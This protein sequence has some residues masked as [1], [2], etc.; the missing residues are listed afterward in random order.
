[1]KT[2]FLKQIV[3]QVNNQS[4]SRG[5]VLALLAAVCLLA[6]PQ[7]VWAGATWIEASSKDIQMG[8]VYA[9]TSNSSPAVSSYTSPSTSG[10]QS[11]LL[12]NADKTFYIWAK[13]ARGYQFSAWT[14]RGG[15]AKAPQT[16]TGNGDVII[17]TTPRAQSVAGTIKATFTPLDAY[18][19]TYLQSDGGSYSAKYGYFLVNAST[20][21]FET[22]SETLTLTPTSGDLKPEGNKT[23]ST[24]DITLSTSSE[25]FVAW[26]KDGAEMSTANPYTGYRADADANISALFKYAQLGTPTGDFSIVVGA[27]S[28]TNYAVTVPVTGRGPWAAGDFTISFAEQTSPAR[29]DIAKGSATYVTV[30]GNTLASTGT[31]SIPFTYS[32]T[33]WGNTEVLV[34]VTPKTGGVYGSSITF[35]IRASAVEPAQYEAEVWENGV[36]TNHG[37][38][39]AMVSYANGLTNNPTVKL[40][41]NKTIAAP[42]SLVQSMTFDLNDMVLTGAAAKAFSIDAADIDVQIVDGGFAGY[43]KISV[44]SEQSGNV[45]VVTFTAKAKLT[46][47][48][49]TL[50]ATNTGTGGAYGLDVRQGSVFYMTGGNL[51][52]TAA[53]DA[54]GVNIATANDFATFNGGSVTVT[55]PT[56]AYGLWSAGTGN[57][58]N[59]TINVTTTTGLEAYGVYVNG[60]VSTVDATGV[61]VTAATTKAYGAYI[62]AG[63]LN[64]NGGSFAVAA[65]TSDVYGVHVAAGATAVVQQ[66]T[67]ITAEATDAAGTGVFGINNLGTV[68]LANIS[69][70]AT[71]PTTNATAVNTVTSAVS[72]TIEGGTY[73]AN[74]GGGT[75][76]GLH[77][78]NGALN[79]D[80][81]IFRAVGGG[82]PIYGGRST[83]NA[84]IANATLYA[85]AQGEGYT[86]YGFVGATASRTITLS[87][88]IITGISNNNKAYA[89]YSRTNVTLTGCTLTATTNKTNEAYGFYAEAGT[90]ALTNCN[91]TVTSNTTTAYGVY[92]KD[93][94]MTITGGQYVVTARQA[95][96]SAAQDAV[97]YGLY[98]AASKTTTVNGASFEVTASNNAFSKNIFG[99]YI[100]GILNSSNATYTATGRTAVYGV[101]GYTAS[102]LTLS[103][104]TITSTATSA[105]TS[106]GIYARKKFTINGDIV[107]AIG[108]TTGVYSMVFDASRSVGDVLDGKFSAQGNGTNS[109]GAINA[110]GTVGNV[111]LKGGVY[112][113]AFNLDKYVYTGYQRFHLDDTHPDYAAGYRYIIATENPSG[114]V[115]RIV[116]GAYYKTLEAALQYTK[117]NSGSNYV[118]VM[119]QHYTLPAGDYELPS[120]ATLLVPYKFEQTAIAGATP[121]RRGTVGLLENFLC[122]TFASGANL[123]VNGKIEVGGELYSKDGGQIS[124]NN[125]PFGRIHM[126]EGSRMQLNNGAFLYAW[127]YITGTGNIIA[128]NKAE[129]HEMFQIGNMQTVGNLY[130]YYNGND[131]KF[132]PFNQYFIQNIEAPTTYYYGSKLITAMYIYYKYNGNGDFYGD[133]AINLVGTSGAFFQVT[134]NDESSWVRKSYDAVHDYQVWEVNSSAQLG[135]ISLTI[136]GLPMI[137]SITVNSGSY[138][139][140]LTSNMKIHVKDGNFAITQDSELLPGASVEINKT[141]T[142]KINSDRKVY[143]FD[144]DQWPLSTAGATVFS[145]GWS[146]GTKPTRT[147][148]DAAINVHGK[149]LATGALYTTNALQDGTNATNG[150]NIYSTDEDAGTVSFETAAPSAQ[151]T[152]KLITGI[153]NKAKVL[154]T[155]TMDPAQLKNKVADPAYT[156]TSGTPTTDSYIY[157]DD[158]WQRAYQNGCFYV[159]GEKVYAK[160]SEYAE[161]QK[162]QT[163]SGKLTG[164]EESNH[165]YLTADDKILILMDDC[166]WWEVEATENAAIF[167]CKKEGYEGFYYY[168]TSSSKWKLKTVTVT[169]YQNETGNTVLKTITTDWKGVP[170]QAMISSNPTK[171]NTD[172]YT[173][174]FYGWESSET[175]TQYKWT[176]VLEAAEDDMSYRPVF[177]ATK[178]HY[179]VTLNNANNGATVYLEVEY[180]EKPEYHPTKNATAQYTYSFVDWT[181]GSNHYVACSNMPTV[182]GKVTYTANWSS[183]VNEYDIIWMNGETLLEKDEDQPYGDPTAY[184]GSQPTKAT[185]DN[186]VYTFSGWKSSLTGSTHANGSTPAVAGNTTYTAQYSTTPR[187]AITFNNY[188]G[189]QLARTIYTQGEIPSCNALPTRTRDRDGY[190]RFDGWKNSAGTKYA[191]D[192]T[193]PAVSKKETYTAQYVYVTD[194]FLITL[195]NVNGNGATWSG[196]FGE[197]STPFYAPDPNNPDVPVTPT[198]ESTDPNYEYIFSGWDPPLQPVSGAAT[199]TAQFTTQVK[200]YSITWII[201][202]VSTTE[203]LEYNSNPTHAV[204]TKEPTAQY[205]YDFT[206]WD[207]QVGPVTGDATYTAQFESTIRKYTITWQNDDGSQIDQ[208]EVEFGTVPTHADA[209]KA[210]D[211]NNVYTFKAWTPT[212]VA[213]DGE[214]T[215]KAT[216]T[217][218]QTVASVTAGG[219][220]TYYATVAAAIDAA[221]GKTNPTVKMLRDASVS[222]EVS[223]ED[224]MTIDLNGKT[225]SSTLNSATGVFKIAASGK[226]VTIQDT[227]TGGKI[228]H[229]GST[230]GTNYLSGVNITDGSLS[231]ESGT[232]YAENTGSSRAYGI[233][234]A[235]NATLVTVS[236]TAVIEA[237][238]SASFGIYTNNSCNFTMNGGTFIASGSTCRGIYVK[239]TSSLTNATITASG[240]SAYAIFAKEGALTIHSGDYTADGTSGC[241]IY[242]ETGTLTV[243]GGRFNG[244]ERELKPKTSYG[245]NKVS[246]KGGVYAHDTDLE[247]NCA[248]NYHVL[249]NADATYQY[250]VAE[251]YTVMFEDGDGNSIQSGYV[252]KGQTPAYTGAKPTKTAI[253]KYTYEFNNTWA[254]TIVPVDGEAT[255]I[256]QFDPTIRKYDITFA[257]LDGR[258]T[259]QT[260]IKVDYDDTPVCPV[261]PEYVDG[262]YEYSFIDWSPQITAVTGEKTY[263]AT[264]SSTATE[265]RYTITW[266]RDDDSK[267]EDTREL[268]GAI[269]THVVPEKAADAQYTYTIAGWSPT[270]VEVV[271]PA[272]YKAT[273]TPTLR[274]YQVTFNMQGHGLAIT[275]QTINYGAKVSQPTAPSATGW[276]FGGW[277]KEAGCTNTWNFASDEVHGTTELFAKW[278]INKHQLTWNWDGGSTSAT[279]GTNYTAPGLVNYDTSL[280]FPANNTMTKTGYTFAGWSSTPSRMPDADLTI[281]ALWNVNKYTVT[282]KNYDGSTLETDTEVP[283]NTTPTY[284]GSTPEKPQTT[285][286]TF[287]FIGWNPTI[288]A[289]AGD[290]IYTAQFSES[291]RLY[292]IT[293]L[294]E[295]GSPF[296]QTQVAYGDVPE[297]AGPEKVINNC[298]YD[299]LGWNVAPEAVTGD[300]TYLATFS[301]NCTQSN[302]LVVFQNHDGTV[303]YADE[304]QGG[305]TPE[306]NGDMPTKPSNAG[307]FNE[308]TGWSPA[309]EEIDDHMVY[310]AQFTE[311]TADAAV[312]KDNAVVCYGTWADA[313]S[314]ANL[315]ANSGCTLRIFNNVTAT[316]NSSISQSMTIDLNG[317]KISCETDATSNTQ[318]FNV[319]DVSLT[320]TDSQGGGSIYYRGTTA[321]NGNNLIYRTIYVTGNSG[322][323]TVKSGKIEAA[324][325]NRAGNSWSRYYANANAV[326]LNSS[327]TSAPQ[328]EVQGG[329]L[330]AT[331][332]YNNNNSKGYAVYF[333][334]NTYGHADVSGGKFKAKTA[335]FQNTSTARTTLSGGYYS[336]DP[337]NNV[338]IATN[339]TKTQITSATVDAEYINGYRYKV[340][341]SSTCTVTW[342]NW[343]GEQIKQTTVTKGNQPVYDGTTPTRAG[344]ESHL[345]EYGFDEWTPA[346][347]TIENDMT[348]TATYHLLVKIS[349]NIDGNITTEFVRFGQTPSHADPV[350]LADAQY[351]YTFAGWEPTITP[352]MC[353]KTYTAKFNEQLNYYAI[354]FEKLDGNS[355]S[356]SY[357]FA[358]GATPVY[359]GTPP[360]KEE[361]GKAYEFLGWKIKNGTDFYEVGESLPTVT[362][363]TTY[364]A[365]FSDTPSAMVYTITWNLG[366]TTE[367]TRVPEGEMPSHVAPEKAATAQYSYVFDGWTPDI[368][369]AT[370]AAT[371]TAKFR[372]VTNKYTI[373]FKD[374]DG[375]VIQSDLLDY[376]TAIVAPANPSRP[377][378]NFNRWSPDVAATVTGNATYT[379]TY[380]GPNYEASV[381][382]AG[383]TEPDYY[384][385]WAQ[386]FSDAQS[387]SGSTLK[388]YTDI[389]VETYQQITQNMTIDLNG[390]TLSR[391]G[392]GNTLLAIPEGNNI[393]LIID[394][395]RGGGG[396]YLRGSASSICRALSMNAGSATIK[397]G[398]IHAVAT[399]NNAAAVYLAATNAT[400]NLNNGTLIAEATNG[401][402][403]G[404]AVYSSGTNNGYSN[405]YGGKL[406][407]KTAIFYNHSTART[408]LQGG[409]YSIDPGTNGTN[410]TIATGYGKQ[411]VTSSEPEYAEGYVKKVVKTSCVV[412]WQNYDGT[413][414]GGDEVSGGSTPTYDGV[415]PTKPA[416]TQYEYVFAGWDPEVSAITDDIIYTAQFSETLRSYTIT[417][418]DGDGNTLTTSEVA[419]GD[420]PSYT[421]L[422]IP[423]KAADAEYTYTYNYTWSPNILAVTG[424]ATY[425][426]GFNKKLKQ[427]TITWMSEDGL[428]TLETDEDIDYGTAT[429]F[430]GSTPTKDPTAQYT[431]TFDGWTTE[432]NGV[433]TFYANGSTPTV[434]GAATYYAHFNA[435]VNNYT[436]TL[437][438]NEDGYG[439]VSAAS[440]ENVPYGT[441]VSTSGNTLTITDKT[442]VTAT[443]TAADAQYTYAF[444]GWSGVPATVTG[445]VTITANFTRTTNTYTV[446]WHNWNGTNLE[447]DSGVEYGA[448][449]S[450][451][452]ATPTR[453]EDEN[454]TYTF[455]GW[456]PDITEV[457]GNAT[458]KAQFDAVSKKRIYYYIDPSTCVET[459]IE[460]AS[461][462]ADPASYNGEDNVFDFDSWRDNG[463]GTFTAQY[464]QGA[465]RVYGKML[466]IINWTDTKIIINAN[467]LKATNGGTNWTIKYASDNYVKGN[468]QGDRTLQITRDKSHEKTNEYVVIKLQGTSGVESRQKYI[469]PLIY[470]ASA[471]LSGTT[472][473]SVVFV[474]EGVTLTVNG[475]TTISKLYVSPGASVK[476]TNGTLTVTDTLALRTL[477]W[478]SASISGSF[479]AGHTYYTRIAPNQSVIPTWD[480]G[481][482]TYKADRYYQFGIPLGTTVALKDVKVS[483]QSTN[484]QYGTS[485][486]VKR[487]DEE[488]RAKNG[489]VDD[490]WV[491]LDKEDKIQPGAGYEMF[492]NLNYYCEYYFPV[493]LSKLSTTTAITYHKDDAGDKHAGWNIVT[494]PLMAD[495]DNSNADP[496]SGLKIGFLQ[497]DGSYVQDVFETIPA[498]IPFSYQASNGQTA[499]SFGQDKSIV[500][501]APHRVSAMEEPV[502]LQWIRL[503]LQDD[504]DRRDQ[505]SILSH[506]TRYDETY[507]P[508]IDV[509]K[510][511]LEA[512]RALIYSSHAYGEMAFAGVAD[513]LLEKG[514]ALTIYSPTAQSLTIS[515]RENNWLN[516]MEYVWLIDTETGTRTDLL[517]DEYSF[518]AAEGTT[519]G[520]FFI[521]GVFA[522]K[523]ATD[524][525]NDG[526]MNDESRVARKLLIR[527]KI[528]IDVNGRRYDATGKLVNGK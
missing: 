308:W 301:E 225:V 5:V 471:T 449:P 143:I 130:D 341:R 184:N 321:T 396:L 486:I 131:E 421:G 340:V 411:D 269:P 274:S 113:S 70:T 148:A 325:P 418:K 180:G 59:A 209:T 231:I 43:G 235:T 83:Q 14:D 464:A 276:T 400:L 213:V 457:T 399:A 280:S 271:G 420:I 432:P 385:T 49:G 60:G 402:Y 507:K 409:Y 510:Q 354:T 303:L 53:T 224:A 149:I 185:D 410:L 215:Y 300:A 56:K 304:V 237:K 111:R 189:E 412:T 484:Y 167:E 334:S 263:T 54:R 508:G 117:D 139:L 406:K 67:T 10:Q 109:Y 172:E 458:Y 337:G 66:N 456:T 253:P 525:P 163:V 256:A 100:L 94:S 431:Y 291:A 461:V 297:H 376:G 240:S 27:L 236:G 522:P 126:E 74:T 360:L 122:L 89:V 261:T 366:S 386:A 210:A 499:I 8:L 389:T 105:A 41:K 234:T 242:Y 265:R 151:A 428:S 45:C 203:E 294:N 518:S 80:G 223:V 36:R 267:I 266:L 436:V 289:V 38:L 195:N 244:T 259:S 305:R 156:S 87:G 494:S 345:Y 380:T 11:A 476:I 134:G 371:Y 491:V 350:K 147:A 255:Y 401:S 521:E 7:G 441:A 455:A 15:Q 468:R 260:T 372:E 368:V 194:M 414:L 365:V 155:V 469:V 24:D 250:K 158:Q 382:Y 392:A 135:S 492:S 125:S 170:D 524:I 359:P 447:T 124:Y 174:T 381:T 311:R 383:S 28:S 387:H 415:T 361:G 488:S 57:I 426:A 316:N 102:T 513:S 61:T 374:D 323:L 138:I 434:G 85:E 46:M 296:D 212:R 81:G 460:S 430:N 312:I 362:G 164:V 324:A 82:S 118:I 515:M 514:V 344:G 133:N 384:G 232:I 243:N 40:L 13:P 208:T 483:D 500:A 512:T 462:P 182:T 201:D 55:A 204:P 333:A 528:Y 335:I 473:K 502:R 322:K 187:Y 42:I 71:S 246:L 302:F 416:T 30:S 26:Y 181:N 33:S 288:S 140:P 419:Y 404:Y 394:D 165:T 50:L 136:S 226:T 505:T 20:V 485:W 378:Y 417:W 489:V 284:N 249:S 472:N 218:T 62:N 229:K 238:S 1:M 348:Y 330:L 179:T 145:P 258:G 356:A 152:I 278:T 95:T 326:Y 501:A 175:G 439:T 353:P 84:T 146:N 160:P 285:E 346:L 228:Y 39:E 309:L 17:S 403:S 391:D 299:F 257:N 397:G 511:S 313:L 503:L 517:T 161:L 142:L 398:T 198:K 112:K 370:E 527:D 408:R 37:N 495:Y 48:G 79:V 205:S 355:Q 221:K 390:Y 343:D 487:Y 127:G 16:S 423:T 319:N 233:N 443:P 157:K 211:A 467:G 3:N 144:T 338:T 251:A 293:W 520:R 120:N 230:S 168:D 9:S 429:A 452:G 413:E 22:K 358:Y 153:S 123:N 369:P 202:G 480:G 405:I 317:Y 437:V 298:R 273:Y 248:T 315:A 427:Y 97:L 352:A 65:P 435:T 116:G 314:Q 422:A 375:T 177:T 69:V 448:T 470:D 498:A 92:H 329:E 328:L 465:E 292:T 479:E 72:T 523:V 264:Y 104:N 58:G 282:W 141:A 197:G 519:S 509:A 88:C 504:D 154:K 25:N 377:A 286:K 393:S 347:G 272:T 2:N 451:D 47:Q 188:D 32:P 137:G 86:A 453:A 132:F 247:A 438:K 367:T 349:W 77:H 463:D 35:T 459:F 466:D 90:N 192:A 444:G 490:N 320:I 107:N 159:V 173:Y 103:G 283:Y 268:W 129:V 327:S 101:Y 52:V 12:Q 191:S 373:T 73:R 425:T 93:G 424:E 446:T 31:L 440:V 433:G 407:A 332:L 222:S 128:K 166:Q 220:T 76:Y 474:H 270:P 279:A 477:P 64:V 6:V 110:T 497:A 307:K 18:E 162:T 310:T 262:A 78:Q 206:G 44:E 108:A 75:A 193:L 442:P 241:A 364:E 171:A 339:H 114:Y 506:P 199:Y 214:A 207:P 496:E 219:T 395:S 227:G 98:T 481:T 150:A 200:K 29:N 287:T 169:F 196:K 306:Y 478:Q 281:T 379:A 68:T 216:Y 23:Y 183:V 331:E 4:N 450:Y 34:T 239:G 342:N 245:T 526:M 290:I 121:N 96:A 91:A 351:T 336:L 115:C 475:N 63:R 51:T 19:V 186:F 254:P 445:N 493:D 217:S 119:T 516:R 454:Y 482:M 99:A 388:I 275:P 106:Y 176:D 21:K 295:D 363:A 277:F 318:L 252:E 190:F 357:Q 178:R